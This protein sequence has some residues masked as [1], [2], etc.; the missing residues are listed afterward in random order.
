MKSKLSMSMVYEVTPDPNAQPPRRP[1][2]TALWIKLIGLAAA[3][4]GLVTVL[5]RVGA[6]HF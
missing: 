2:K 4:I 5:I 3:V 1:H 6:I